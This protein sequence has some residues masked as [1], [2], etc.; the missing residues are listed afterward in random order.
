MAILVTL[1][2]E[3]EEVLLELNLEVLDVNVDVD[4]PAAAT[5]AA[6]AAARVAVA[7]AASV[8]TF[9][10]QRTAVEHLAI[11]FAGGPASIRAPARLSNVGK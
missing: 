5:A 6:A 4:V 8:G 10:L 9:D 2:D 1:L 11:Q 3:D 7:G